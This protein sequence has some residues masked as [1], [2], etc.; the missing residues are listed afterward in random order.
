M[1]TLTRKA[2]DCLERKGDTLKCWWIHLQQR[3]RLWRSRIMRDYTK[4][5][6]KRLMQKILA[7]QNQGGMEEQLRRYRATTTMGYS[8]KFQSGKIQV[9]SDKK[10]KDGTEIALTNK[11]K[12][13]GSLSCS[14]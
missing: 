6:L 11:K 3:M 13:K 9:K 8:I 5:P 12:S 14:L 1:I 2:L 10:L 4:N 7:L